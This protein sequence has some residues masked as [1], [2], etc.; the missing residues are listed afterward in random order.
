MAFRRVEA[1]KGSE[2]VLEQ[3]K[4]MIETGDYAPGSKLP[5]VVELA[6]SFEVGRSTIR[7][8]LSGLKATGWITIRH[9]G[10]SYVSLELPAAEDAASL[11][12]GK[13]KL[14]EVLEV[15]K[16]IEAGC[17]EL[18]AERRSA[19]DLAALRD[20][21]ERMG[22]ALGDEAA[23]DEADIRFHL[24]VAEASKNALLLS[25]MESMA[26]RLRESMKQSRRLWF[27]AERASAE[28]LLAEHRS[29]FEAIETRDGAA[30]RDRM[31][32]HLLK[33][34]QVIERSE[35][36]GQDERDERGRTE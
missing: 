13:E 16:F 3:L 25:M 17:A 2:L 8:A 5:T 6:D 18:A 7:E 14:Q 11:S 31:M 12:F 9:G 32:K 36:S 35:R 33:V 34:E 29:I 26:G 28:Q 15:R 24:R 21:L 30:A 4:N 23:S 1:R 19:E 22:G 27:F 10:G 20:I